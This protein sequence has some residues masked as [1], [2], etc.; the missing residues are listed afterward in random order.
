MEDWGVV[1]GVSHLY[2]RASRVWASKGKE[3]WDGD[4][5]SSWEGG[6]GI[7]GLPCGLEWTDIGG[8]LVMLD[9]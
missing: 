9:L 8:S 5:G 3:D 6:Q 4:L 7:M 1:E 2:I